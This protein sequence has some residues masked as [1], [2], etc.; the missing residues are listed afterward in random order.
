MYVNRLQ[1]WIVKAV[2]NN[3]WRLVK[4][5][6]KLVTNSFFAKALA[7]KRVATNK[8]KKTP[9][10]DGDIWTTDGDKIW[11]MK[12]IDH[13]HLSVAIP[14]KFIISKF[15]GNLKGKITLMIYDCHSELQSKWD[16]AF[17]ARGYCV[18]TIDNITEDAIRKYIREQAEEPRKEDS[19]STA[20]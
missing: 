2:Q 17:W 8:G 7:V 3:K 1:V 20:L 18:S 10:I 13:V 5:L 11:M 12:S 14:P 16:K 4:R 19:R 6:Q 9:G 15:M